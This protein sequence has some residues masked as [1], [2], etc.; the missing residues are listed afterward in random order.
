MAPN[1]ARRLCNSAAAPCDIRAGRKLSGRGL[2]DGPSRPLVALTAHRWLPG[3][4]TNCVDPFP[5]DLQPVCSGNQEGSRAQKPYIVSDFKTHPG[6]RRGGF[7]PHSWKEN[8]RETS[9]EVEEK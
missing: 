1:P 8:Q 3:R 5:S 4:R 7:T 2:G 9:R 6:G